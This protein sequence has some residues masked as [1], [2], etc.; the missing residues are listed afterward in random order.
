MTAAIAVLL[1][2]A[3][4]NTQAQKKMR[5]SGSAMGTGQQ[6]GNV[7]SVDLSFNE[8]STAD[9]QKALMSAYEA[10]GQKGLV[11]ALDKMHAK[12]RV[13]IT[14]TLGFD[15]N[16]IRQFNMPDGSIKYRFVTDRPI[17]FGEAWADSRSMDYSV[18]MGEIII[19]KG[20]GKGEKSTGTL[21]PAAKV[22]LNEDK[23]LGI[24][25]YQNPWNLVAIKVW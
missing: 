16:Y 22:K 13:A 24:E 5:I 17:T 15:L 21:M 14:G 11:N 1:L 8:Y 25:T 20:K 10:G 18:S 2:A 7:V 12:G 3:G 4:S 6:I 9:D 23:E 19:R